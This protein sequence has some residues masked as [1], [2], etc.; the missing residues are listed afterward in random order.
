MRCG[1]GD[2]KGFHKVKVQGR[3]ISLFAKVVNEWNSLTIFGNSSVLHVLL[4]SETLLG[5]VS[6][7]FR[8][9]TFHEW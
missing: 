2:Y 8:E 1:G 5:Q 4:S 7:N 9:I 6:E 3:I